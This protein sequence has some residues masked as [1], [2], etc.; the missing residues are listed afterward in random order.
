MFLIRAAFW[1]SVAILLI[2]TDSQTGEAPRVTLVNA[3]LAAKATVADLSAFCDRN[4]D[5]CVTSGAAFELFAEKAESGVQMIY[6]YLDT[7][8]EPE[9]G[10]GTLRQDDI[11]L[12]WKGA[13]G[14]PA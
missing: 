7:P 12:P 9:T 8:P 3:F 4:P 1:L 14:G 6:N 2:P 13:D 11:A 5:V 10:A